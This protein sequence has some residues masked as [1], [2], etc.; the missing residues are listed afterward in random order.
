M[1]IVEK[2]ER[3]LS[4]VRGTLFRLSDV[5]KKAQLCEKRSLLV[6]WLFIISIFQ[7]IINVPSC[8]KT[9]VFDLKMII[10]YMA[11]KH[12][13]VIRIVYILPIFYSLPSFKWGV[14]G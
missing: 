13:L 7:L 9:K 3:C 12:R 11:F 1:F 4:F 5:F 8:C 2:H 6:N 10:K 14:P